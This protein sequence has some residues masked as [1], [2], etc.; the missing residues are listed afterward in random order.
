MKFCVNA[1]I[2][3]SC[4]A[5]GNSENL[6][7]FSSQ[8]KDYSSLSHAVRQ[9]ANKV[10][11][12]SK[13]KNLILAENPE[14]FAS[15]DFA[16]KLISDSVN[17]PSGVFRLDTSSRINVIRGHRK[18]VVILVTDSFDGFLQIYYKIS[19]KLF[20][21]NAFYVIVLSDHEILEIEEMFKLLWTIQIYNVNIIFEDESSRVSV[22]TFIPFNARG[23]NDT[24]PTLI[25]KFMDGNFV[26]G[27]N[28]FFPDKMKNLYKCPVRV[29]IS[30]DSEPTV[31]VKYL[32]N[33][34]IKLSGRDINIL[35]TLSDSL[36]F[37]IVY[38]YIGEEGYLYE[39]GSYAGSLGTIIRGGAD[40]SISDWWLKANRLKFLDSSYGYISEQIVLIVPPGRQLSTFEKLI[41]PFDLLVWVMI[42]ICFLV[43]F[44]II[45]VI[46]LQ[47]QS[48]QSFVFGTKVTT[49][50]L[51]MFVA[52]IGGTQRILPTNNFARF[53]LM[54]FLMYS[55]VVRTLYQATFYRLMQ[56]NKQ[57]IEVTSID[58]MIAED[59]KFYLL[60]WHADVFQG[61]ES[62][63]DRLKF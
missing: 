20:R 24:T 34:T 40:L 42:S 2:F 31:F 62:M 35:E 15:K 33:G 22:Q 48:I 29:A 59:F 14:N 8:P 7:R 37:S 46:R 50:Y 41:Y 10:A 47:R 11:D 3:V 61:T 12:Y 30:N 21:L 57:H 49:P 1:L 4:W 23:C 60:P 18:R 25:D 6:R 43:G 9:V 19:S 36:N 27:I 16:D 44:I 38:T 53:L 54:V 45:F 52:F 63:R 56:S 13:T 51:N 5:I 58:E 55:M 17:D 32:S 26:N 39:N 28:N